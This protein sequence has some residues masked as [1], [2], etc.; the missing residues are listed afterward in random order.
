[1]QVCTQIQQK[2][3]A[4]CYAHPFEKAPAVA[5]CALKRRQEQLGMRANKL[6]NDCPVR[7]NSTVVMLQRLLEQRIAVQSVLSDEA[8]TKPSV[9]KSLAMKA[10]QWELVEQLIPVL[11]PLAKATEIMCG[12]QH[13]G[14][15]F[16]Y[17]LIFS[18]VSPTLHVQSSDLAA[19]H[20]FKIM[21]GEQLK[22]R[23]KLDSDHLVES[24][25]IVACGL[26]AWF[27]HLQFSLG[28]LGYQFY[29]R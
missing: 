5:T 29:Y 14:L 15:S 13:V 24:I 9:Q 10:P 2:Y 26:D 7:W 12:E 20:N 16:I 23:F 3:Y 25:P 17:P 28:K 18:M 19:V 27:K 22:K 8:V 4:K 1:M 21:V 6:Q 11:Q